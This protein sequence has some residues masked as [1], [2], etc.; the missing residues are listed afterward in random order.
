MTVDV[1]HPTLEL[2]KNRKVTLSAWKYKPEFLGSNFVFL[3]TIIA[4]SIYQLLYKQDL[5]WAKVGTVRQEQYYKQGRI[6][7]PRRCAG[8]YLFLDLSLAPSD[9]SLALS[10]LS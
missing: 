4:L 7:G 9:L 8:R 3:K 6:H 1:N 5:L 2:L 10:D